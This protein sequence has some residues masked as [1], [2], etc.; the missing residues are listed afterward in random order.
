MKNLIAENQESMLGKTTT[1]WNEEYFLLRMFMYYRQCLMSVTIA[2][3]EADFF[4]ESGW[5]R[6]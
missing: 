4:D 1:D 3:Y 2:K 5:H 6:T